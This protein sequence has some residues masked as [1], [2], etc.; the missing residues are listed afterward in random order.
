MKGWH[1][2]AL[3]G[4]EIYH[5]F[6]FPSLHPS[7]GDYDYDGTQEQVTSIINMVF[8]YMSDQTGGSLNLIASKSKIAITGISEKEI[9]G[10]ISAVS[11]KEFLDHSYDIAGK[12]NTPICPSF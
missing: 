2:I 9:Q 5:I 11:S 10:Q 8:P 7:I 4:L 12:F 3:N 6:Y 1:F